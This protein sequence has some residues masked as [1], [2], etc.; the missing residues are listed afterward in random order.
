MQYTGRDEQG[1]L[2]QPYGKVNLWH[3]FAGSDRITF[4]SPAP[5]E[6]RFGG[7]AVEVGGG[8]TARVNANTS[9]YA[10]ADYRWSI[11]GGRARTSA[12]QGAI[13]IRFNW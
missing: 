5:I 11:D 1:T 12:T 4:G 13:G 2:W 8:V 3:A 6:N 10:H 7:T 9:F